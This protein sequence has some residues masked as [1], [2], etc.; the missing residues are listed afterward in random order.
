MKHT[1]SLKN[2]YDF[3]RL[4][5]KGKSK[6][7][8]LLAVYCRFNSRRYNRLGLTTGAKL[9]NAVL[10]NRLRRRIREAYRLNEDKLRTGCDIVVVGRMRAVKADYRAIEHSL[11]HLFRS[12]GLIKH[13]ETSDKTD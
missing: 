12:L 4:Y 2:N 3:R 9:G 6:A 10:R 8:P 1:Y 11:I 7:D 13:E 5:A